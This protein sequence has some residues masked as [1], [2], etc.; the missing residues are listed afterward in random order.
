MEERDE[1]NPVQTNTTDSKYI[2]DNED[3]IVVNIN[4]HN[5]KK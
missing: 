2:F 3:A 1:F 4:K 5:N